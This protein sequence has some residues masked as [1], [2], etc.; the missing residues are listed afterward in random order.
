[1]RLSPDAAP[2]PSA[3]PPPP[4]G[5][6]HGP[7]F[8]GPALHR[9]ELIDRLRH[10]D[11][12]SRQRRDI[13]EPLRLAQVAGIVTGIDDAENRL[14]QARADHRCAMAPHQHH[15]MPARRARERG[16][17][18]G[19]ATRRLVSPNSS[20]ASQNGATAPMAA[21]RWNTGTIG[22]PLMQN[23]ITRGRMMMADRRDVGPR[24]EDFAVDDPLGIERHRHR[25]DRLR[26]PDRIRGCRRGETSSGERERARK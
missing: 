20:R 17:L 23:G 2:R 7:I 14:A 10:F 12:A 22:S 11:L 8:P 6:P 19:L 9:R 18:R 4:L 21:P 16:A 3:A 13:A 26:T 24:L 1:M 5:K 25:L 15:R